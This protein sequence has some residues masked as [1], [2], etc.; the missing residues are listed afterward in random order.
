[1]TTFWKLTWVELKLFAREPVSVLFTFAFPLVMLVVL[2]GVFG[3]ES[4]AESFFGLRPTDYYGAAY[5]S[6]VIAAIGLVAVPVHL[7]G[8][9][10][11]GVLRRFRASSVP[12]TAVIGSQL[13]VGLVATVIGAVVLVI[14]AVLLY[15]SALPES[16]GGAVLS[17]LV[18]TVAFLGLGLLLGSLARNARSAQALGMLLFFPL[19]ILS[20]AGP[21]HDVMGDAMANVAGVLPLT[22]VVDASLEPWL[23]S[24]LSASNLLLLLGLLVVS[25]A[26]SIRRL[27][28]T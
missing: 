9:R 17:M 2:A 28:P 25:V 1:M 24:G 8:Y 7:A 13:L 6:V 3:S 14:A 16:V 11:R 26:V 21:P 4:E 23:F 22:W 18:A 12:V 27:R 5:P 20:G 19:V 15:D 10:E